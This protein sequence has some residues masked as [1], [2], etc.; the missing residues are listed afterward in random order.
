MLRS[1]IRSGWSLLRRVPVLKRVP[2]L[3]S[4]IP[5]SIASHTTR[6]NGGVLFPSVQEKDQNNRIHFIRQFQKQRRLEPEPPVVSQDTREL[7]N[8]I[9]TN[10]TNRYKTVEFILTLLEIRNVV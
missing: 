5:P 3:Y 4:C 10:I 6:L 9:W 7:F 1:S 8:E 2:V